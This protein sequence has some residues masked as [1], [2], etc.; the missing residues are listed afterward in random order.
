MPAGPDVPVASGRPE[1]QGEVVLM[2][3]KHQV[4]ELAAIRAV[5]ERIA[6]ALEDIAGSAASAPHGEHCRCEVCR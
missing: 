5:L 2:W 4:A 6:S 1:P 3:E